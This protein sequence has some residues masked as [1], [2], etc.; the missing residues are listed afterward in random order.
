[1]PTTRNRW[2][3]RNVEDNSVHPHITLS[4]R[5]TRAKRKYDKLPQDVRLKYY[6]APPTK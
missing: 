3:L 4:V 2:T 5:A 6:L 1:M